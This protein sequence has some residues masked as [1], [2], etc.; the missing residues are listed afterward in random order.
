MDFALPGT[1]LIV[2][3]AF[4]PPALFAGSI[5]AA[6]RYRQEPGHALRGAFLWG[7]TGAAFLALIVNT[8]ASGAL[9]RPYLATDGLAEVATAI[10]VAP[11]VEEAVKPLVLFMGA[12][13]RHCDEPVDGFI[14]GA[15]AGLG[16]SATE[17]L[18]YEVAALNQNGAAGFWATAVARTFSSSLLHA[19][20]T[21]LTGYGIARYLNRQSSFLGVV[22]YFL[23]AVGLHAAFN[24][25]ASFDIGFGF[26]PLVVLAVFGFTRVRRR[27]RELSLVAP[28]RTWN[29]V[30]GQRPAP[31]RDDVPG[32]GRP[33]GPTA[34]EPVRRPPPEKWEPVR[35]RPPGGP[36]GEPPG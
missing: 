21:A 34:W 32:A 18:L 17:N 8:L 10:L 13:R 9:V 35:R 33:R 30:G 20:A 7:A 27:I 2:A 4:G 12:V 6:K 29:A 5:A 28:T 31:P 19:T 36:P 24:T 25:L 26:I 14:Y 15:I 22:P 11:I 23:G 16:F 3:V 1:L